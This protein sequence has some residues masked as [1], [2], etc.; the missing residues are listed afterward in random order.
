MGS[1]QSTVDGEP[2]FIIFVKQRNRRFLGQ[3]VVEEI[4]FCNM[5]RGVVAD[6]ARAEGDRAHR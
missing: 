1:A 2:R 4:E 3:V 5:R 6:R